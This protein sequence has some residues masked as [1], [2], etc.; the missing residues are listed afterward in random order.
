MNLTRKV[1]VKTEGQILNIAISPERTLY[2]TL[3]TL[4]YMR[5]NTYNY[6]SDTYNNCAWRRK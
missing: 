4:Q 3:D 5:T 2:N 6:C 1:K